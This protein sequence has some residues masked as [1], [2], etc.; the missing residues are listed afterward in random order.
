MIAI[1]V[2]HNILRSC[3]RL[4]ACLVL[5]ERIASQRIASHR[6]ASHRVLLYLYRP[7]PAPPLDW[8]WTEPVAYGPLKLEIWGRKAAGKRKKRRGQE[9]RRE[10]EGGKR[11]A[12]KKKPSVWIIFS[13][14][15]RSDKR[16][17]GGGVIQ[18]DR[19]PI[20]MMIAVSIALSVAIIYEPVS[21]VCLWLW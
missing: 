7:Q 5:L 21:P 1:V 6:I 2:S 17:R 20:V 18:P 9:E 10:E 14:R 19:M 4:R 3:E 12:K 13:L 16:R 15:W 11:K 8:G